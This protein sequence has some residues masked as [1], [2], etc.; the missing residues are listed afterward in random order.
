MNIYSF[1]LNYREKGAFIMP[2]LNPPH[3]A[4]SLPAFYIDGDGKVAYNPNYNSSWVD[5]YKGLDDTQKAD[6]DKRLIKYL[7]EEKFYKE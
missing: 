4:T 5:I 6:V 7:S 1:P 3:L 2:K